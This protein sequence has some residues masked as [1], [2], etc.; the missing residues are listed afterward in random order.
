MT[1]LSYRNYYSITVVEK[2]KTSS[3][4][5]NIIFLLITQ[6][7]AE[8]AQRDFAIIPFELS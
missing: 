4:F 6:L 1:P 2:K 8:S 5:K 3:E 7:L